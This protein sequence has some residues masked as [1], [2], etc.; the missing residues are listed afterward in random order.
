MNP[1][2]RLRKALLEQLSALHQEGVSHLPKFKLEL[3]AGL[4]QAPGMPA[5]SGATGSTLARSESRLDRAAAANSPA[6]LAAKPPLKGSARPSIRPAPSKDLWVEGGGNE[7]AYGPPL[8]PAVRPQALQIIQTEVANC[9]RCPELAKSRHKTVFGTGNPLARLCFL[10]E[11]P[12]ADEDLQGQP[13]V[14]AAG[15]LLDKIMTACQ[16]KR[17]DVYILNTIKCR[18]PLNRPPHETELQNCRNFA[19]RQLELIQPEFI[20][21]LGSVAAK[22]LLMTNKS[23]G[24]LR[25]IFHPYRG[26]RVLVTYHP[27]YLL[28]TP[29]AKRHVWDDMKL[30]LNEM[31]IQL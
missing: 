14:G 6:P 21:C 16:L 10:G 18:P 23:V 26:S 19:V 20:C 3:P 11:A 15:Q 28:R 13:F 30:L 24:Q 27:A 9:V 8:D 25:G 29:T 22:S 1:R 17:E 12:G 2:E 4:D 5:S 7:A 31:G